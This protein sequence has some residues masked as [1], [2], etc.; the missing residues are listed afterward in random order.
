MVGIGLVLGFFTQAKRLRTNKSIIAEKRINQ[1]SIH[2]FTENLAISHQLKNRAE[3]IFNINSE[4]DFNSLALDLFH[5][6][7]DHNTVYRRWV[8]SLK[9]KP[10]AVRAVEE[11]PFLPISF[12][13]SERV[14]SSPEH[15]Q[16]VVFTSSSTTSHVPSQHLVND[17][18]VYEQ[19]FLRG[20]HLF[21]GPPSQYCV[22]ALLPGYLERKSSSLVYMCHRLIRESGHPRG[23][24]FLDNTAGLISTIEELKKSRQ[25]VLL[26]GVSYALMDLSEKIKLDENFIVMETGG[27]KG[28]RK[29]LLKEEL[30]NLLKNNF[31]VDQIHSEY[32]M[33]ELLSQAY[34]RGDGLFQSPPWMRFMIREV[35]D[36]LNILGANQTGGI[37]VADLA[38]IH[39]CC[40]I[41]TQD[42]GRINDSNQL[43]LMGRYDNS[44]VRGCNLMVS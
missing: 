23:G 7:Y 4:G 10:E 13:K 36:P 2:K 39:S 18:S 34:S 26:I 6:Q 33:T 12:F 27:M 5:F 8:S 17:I 30:H 21:Y 19:S 31:G 41:A 15:P 16:T 42:L 44:D 20:F 25:K 32:G 38:N 24:F 1:K 22:L 35:T 29:E 28:K 43:Q 14:V 11:I 37:N 40:F 9:V 3:E